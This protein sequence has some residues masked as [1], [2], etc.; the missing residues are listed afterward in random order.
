M[1]SARWWAQMLVVESMQAMEVEGP[2][3]L[4][5]ALIP[6]PKPTLTY[7]TVTAAGAL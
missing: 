2:T 5:H 6:Y 1:L 7:P 4:K 3:V